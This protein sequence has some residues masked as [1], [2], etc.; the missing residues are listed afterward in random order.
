MVVV[1]PT[2]QTVARLRPPRTT[3]LRTP[4][5]TLLAPLL[6]FYNSK[7]II[8]GACLRPIVE[9]GAAARNA[10][11]TGL[12]RLRVYAPASSASYLLVEFIDETVGRTKEVDLV[13]GGKS[14]YGLS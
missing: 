8:G 2:A 13:V 5:T 14:V 11:D 7:R 1:E 9:T 3:A 6:F 10:E 4:P 12:L